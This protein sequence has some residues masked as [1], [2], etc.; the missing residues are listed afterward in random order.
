M[1]GLGVVVNYLFAQNKPEKK[2][3]TQTEKDN[4]KKEEKPVKKDN[5]KKDEK[6]K[7]D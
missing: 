3:K 1:F 2:D 6:K 4:K 5:K 7:E